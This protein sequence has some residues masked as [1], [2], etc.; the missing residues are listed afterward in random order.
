MRPKRSDSLTALF[1]LPRP[2]FRQFPH[3]LRE[4]GARWF[5]PGSEVREVDC[6]AR[7]GALRVVAFGVQVRERLRNLPSRYPS[8]IHARKLTDSANLNIFQV[9]EIMVAGP[10]LEPGTYGL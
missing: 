4:F 10:G 5:V 9:I 2:E 8:G 3:G 6:G 1:A 7:K